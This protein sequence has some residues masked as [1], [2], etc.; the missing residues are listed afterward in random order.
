MPQEHGATV[1]FVAKI[2][3]GRHFRPNLAKQNLSGLGA[4]R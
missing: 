3:A 1:P 2:A 4:L